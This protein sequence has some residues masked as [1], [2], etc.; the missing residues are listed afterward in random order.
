MDGSGSRPASLIGLYTGSAGGAENSDATSPAG[1]SRAMFRAYLPQTSGTALPT[2]DSI[3]MLDEL[4][5][6]QTT[7][8]NLKTRSAQARNGASSVRDSARSR[9]DA[10]RSRAEQEAAELERLA[11]SAAAMEDTAGDDDEL[12]EGQI[13]EENEVTQQSSPPAPQLPAATAVKQQAPSVVAPRP[14]TTSAASPSLGT[15][16]QAGS[17]SSHSRAGSKDLVPSLIKPSV[18]KSIADLPS[19]PLRPVPP[20]DPTPRQPVPVIAGQPPLPD[21]PPPPLPP[22]P[23]PPPPPD[24]T[25]VTVPAATVS[26]VAAPD[27]SAGTSPL[28]SG[29]SAVTSPSTRAGETLSSDTRIIKSPVLPKEALILSLPDKQ[30]KRKRESS[31]SPGPSAPAA[32]ETTQKRAR[33]GT[34]ELEVTVAPAVASDPSVSSQEKVTVETQEVADPTSSAPA[35]SSATPAPVPRLAVKLKLNPAS[36]THFQ[37]AAAAAAAA[38]AAGVASPA[39]GPATPVASTSAIGVPA[40]GALPGRRDSTPAT[41]GGMIFAPPPLRPGQIGPDGRMVGFLPHPDEPPSL[42]WTLPIRTPSSVIPQRPISHPA[43]PYARAPEEVQ[44]DWTSWDWKAGVLGMN[45]QVGP[46]R[47]GT[48]ALADESLGTPGPSQDAA[49][50]QATRK[51]RKGKE[52]QQTPIL[53]FYAYAD[54][55]FKTLTEDD[56]A[57][58][59]AE[60]ENP[61]PFQMPALGRYYRDVW[62]EEDAA[63]TAAAAAAGYDI[64]AF[65]MS[66]GSWAGS[67]RGRTGSTPSG[68]LGTP[69]PDGRTGAGANA[70]RRRTRSATMGGLVGGG[71]GGVYSNTHAVHFTP[72]QMRDGH[73]F[74]DEEAKGGPL[75]E[76]IVSALMPVAE[77]EGEAEGDVPGDGVAV[78]EIARPQA[79]EE[80]DVAMAASGLVTG[81]DTAGPSA[82]A[83]TDG[84]ASTGFPSQPRASS[85][86]KLTLKQEPGT[87][88]DDAELETE[89]EGDHDTDLERSGSGALSRRDGRLGSA[90]D[91]AAQ[92]QDLA[93][94]ESRLALELRAISVLS[95]TEAGNAAAAAAKEASARA[96]R[97]D[98]EDMDE[99][100][101]DGDGD[102]EADSPSSVSG[103]RI[104]GGGGD[105]KSGRSSL[106]FFD[107]TL[108]TDDEISSALRQAQRA[109]REQMTINAARKKRLFEIAHDR[110]AYQDYANAL[111]SV[112]KDVETHWFKRQKQLKTRRDREKERE[113]SGRVRVRPGTNA[114]HGPLTHAEMAA[115]AVQAGYSSSSSS[116]SPSLPHATLPGVVPSASSQGATASGPGG[117]FAGLPEPLAAALERRQ[118]LRYAF[119]PLFMDVCPH[120]WKTPRESV[121]G[122]LRLAGRGDGS[123]GSNIKTRKMAAEAGPAPAP[124]ATA[125]EG[126][127]VPSAAMETPP[128]ETQDM[129]L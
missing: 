67:V 79:G 35:P 53:T 32:V 98:D 91:H 2:S 48:P 51:D 99:G 43:K 124:V 108:R 73:L 45:P 37:N 114:G 10:L 113:A 125:V 71:T 59:S 97:R 36:R 42:S 47:G 9:R 57:W 46:A 63:M 117:P 115:A 22:G 52:I 39:P 77:E 30:K 56:L 19:I 122:D 107:P 7:L 109:L 87:E 75:T 120:S 81:A 49:G 20:P 4:L 18:L 111:S 101:L 88:A 69:G 14:P 3:P 66:G 17:S 25:P 76:R 50:R 16:S 26:A 72:A 29:P 5:R 23:P 123:G 127:A 104:G 119:D 11:Q 80:Q 34:A 31:T 41:T 54:A 28:T 128:D 105:S 8:V 90:R 94:F 44:V 110:M 116:D 112:E 96:S 64:S 38:R 62:A 82:S 21:A 61:E 58:L 6:L 13:V 33:S 74:R 95:P 68:F 92:E 40:Q 103:N 129:E 126:A 106:A 84:V 65:D 60:S 1:P 86:L 12:E 89:G 70:A 78:E 121:F 85:P 24:E 27:L 118:K 100:D 102:D 93:S 83:G 55:F 15:D